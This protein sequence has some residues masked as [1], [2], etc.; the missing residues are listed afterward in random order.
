[1]L[2]HHP[3]QLRLLL[4]DLKGGIELALFATTPH[5]LG[6]VTTTFEGAAEAPGT[7][8]F[9]RTR[10]QLPQGYSLPTHVHPLVNA[11]SGRRP[12]PPPPPLGCGAVKRGGLEG[13]PPGGLRAKWAAPTWS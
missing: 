10:R 8:G 12:Q 3:D 6:D 4:L 5:S 2:I 13:S 1:V 7:A 9:F 11:I